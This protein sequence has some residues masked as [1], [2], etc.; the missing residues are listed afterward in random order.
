VCKSWLVSGAFLFNMR[1]SVVVAD[2]G[3]C[4]L[5]FFF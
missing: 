5:G 1:D 3:E 4:A 2:H